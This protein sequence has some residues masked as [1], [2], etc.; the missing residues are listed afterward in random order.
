[1]LALKTGGFVYYQDYGCTLRRICWDP[2]SAVQGLRECPLLRFFQALLFW[3]FHKNKTNEQKT[4]PRCSEDKLGLPKTP[5]PRGYLIS[6]QLRL[7]LSTVIL[8]TCP[9]FTL[10]VYYVQPEKGQYLPGPST[11]GE[12]ITNKKLGF[13][14]LVSSAGLWEQQACSCDAGCL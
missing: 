12:M 9:W 4:A 14:S 1:M 3:I 11:T 13:M 7:L 2:R 6:L 8:G 5:G 10:W